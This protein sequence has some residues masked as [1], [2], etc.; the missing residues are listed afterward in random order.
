MN[1][2]ITF[3]IVLNQALTLTEENYLKAMYLLANKDD[4]VS[5]SDLSKKLEVSSPTANS[6]VK[7][8]HQKELVRYEKYKP[9]LITKMGKLKAAYVIRKHRLTEMYL[10]EKMGFG[11]EEVHHIAEQVEHIKA[12]VFFD[13]MDE[14]LGYPKVD[15][16][17]SP[18]PDKDGKVNA[19]FFQPLSNCRIGQIVKL[20]S[21]K[22]SE[23]EFLNFLNSKEIELGIE[24]EIHQIE[25]FDKSMEVSYG[26]RKKEVI[27]NL[28]S[29]RLLVN[30]IEK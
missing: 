8:M 15:P 28:V 29:E 4:E 21:L 12:P 11:W 17:G 7:N 24:I 22:N 2:L 25:S 13:K 27:S 3:A 14:I 20:E 16:H 10:V 23:T 18:I 19:Q 1:I 26:N 9:I 6:M 5:L 30:I